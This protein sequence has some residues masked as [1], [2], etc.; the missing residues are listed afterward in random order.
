MNWLTMLK[1]GALG[2]VTFGAAYVAANPQVLTHLIPANV[3]QM[4]IGGAVA[5]GLVMAANWLKN[6][7]T[8]SA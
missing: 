6:K 2:L 8:P 3:S 1:K 7:N 4:T 5:A